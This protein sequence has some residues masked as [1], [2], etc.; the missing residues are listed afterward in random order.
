[1]LAGLHAVA[2]AALAVLLLPLPPGEATTSIACDQIPY[3]ANGTFQANLNLLAKSLPASASAS[4]GGFA[5]ATVGT[6]PDQVN[7]LA[8]CRGDT[9]ASACDT[10]VAAAF[11]DAQQNCSLDRGVT[12]FR[13]GCHLRFASRQFL[14]FLRPDQW[15]VSELVYVPTALE[16][17]VHR[18]RPNCQA[19]QTNS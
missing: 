1:M 6:A 3:T 12:V 4:P 15:I 5:N 13:D 9:N 7:G 16:L 19:L 2:V 8:L 11:R 18:F 17:F 10:C 14:D